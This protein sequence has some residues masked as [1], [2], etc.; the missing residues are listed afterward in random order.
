M[1]SF[2]VCRNP[3]AGKPY[4]IDLFNPKSFIGEK[5]SM[6][7]RSKKLQSAWDFHSVISDRLQPPSEDTIT[8]RLNDRDV[9]WPYKWAKSIPQCDIP[10]CPWEV[11]Q[12][13]H[14]DVFYTE[15]VLTSFRSRLTEEEWHNRLMALL[16]NT[17]SHGSRHSW[18]PRLRWWSEDRLKVL[19]GVGLLDAI[20]KNKDSFEDWAR[21]WDQ[22]VY[23]NDIDNAECLLR[24]LCMNR[25]Q[26]GVREDLYKKLLQGS[27]SSDF[28]SFLASILAAS[29]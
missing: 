23:I 7:K 15:A 16:I 29:V 21:K 2:L 24:F 22:G 5:I 10:P 4:Q 6:G 26:L 27:S 19:Q 12:D 3:K 11:L 8:T 14:P 28:A 20:A 1:L 25:E 17:H 18:I 13:R 9:E